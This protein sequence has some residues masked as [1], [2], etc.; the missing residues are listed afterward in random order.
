MGAPLV[1]VGCGKMGGA[2]LE[3]WLDQGL[4]VDEAIIVEPNDDAARE[5][6]ER[7]GVRVYANADALPDA[8]SPGIVVFAVKPQMADGVVPHYGKFAGPETV[9]LSV[10]AGKP[11]DYFRSLLGDGAAVVRSM[12]NTPAAVRRGMSVACAGP[13][14]SPEQQLQCAGLLEA[15][16][17]VAWVDDESLMDAVTAVSGSGPA[18][19]FYMVECMTKAGVAAGLPEETATRLARATV[20]GAGELVHQTQTP[21]ET[22][23]RNVTSPGG[24][25]AA[26]LDVLMADDGLQP[27]M[28]KAVGAAKKRSIELA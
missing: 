2:M 11:I 12:P 28:T 22:L 20:A 27:L 18:Y 16:G 14:V 21:A 9:F 17:D 25:T 6:T 26:A 13:G 4:S 24:T 8:L 3:G 1:L 5:L 19:V 10:A 7:L 23:R 15:V